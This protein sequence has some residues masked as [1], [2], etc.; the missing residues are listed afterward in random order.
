MDSDREVLHGILGH[1]SEEHISIYSND[2]LQQSCIKVPVLLNPTAV[3]FLQPLPLPTLKQ[4]QC[5]EC[6]L[7]CN[8]GVFN[9][10]TIYTYIH[11]DYQLRQARRDMHCSC[12]QL[13]QGQGNITKTW[14]IPI[15]QNMAL[16]E[17][18]GK[19]PLYW[20]LK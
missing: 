16:Q 6:Q 3:E 9:R 19:S 1:C 10:T 7:W 4:F 15:S 17:F 14:V 8:A 12:T 11:P 13:T 20:L 5:Y 2:Q 18:L